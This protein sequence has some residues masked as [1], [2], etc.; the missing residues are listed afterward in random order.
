M[1][2]TRVSLRRPVAIL[3]LAAVAAVAAAVGVAVLSRGTDDERPDLQR[4]LDSLVTGPNRI[5]PGVAAYVAGPHGSWS[6]SAGVANA[7]TGARMRPDARFRLESV[8]KL[9]TATV[10]L[11]LVAEGKLRLDD[12]VAHRL[13][14][15]LPYGDRITVRELLDHTSGMVDTNDIDHNPAYY[16]GRVRDPALRAR[17][18][19]VARRVARDPG[20]EFSP[21]LWIRFAAALPLEYPPRTTYHYSNIGYMVAGLIAE[22]VGG[23]DLAKLVREQ[24][25]DPLGLDSAAYDPSAR[26][27]GSHAQGYTVGA[28]GK[29]TDT[30]TWT[31]G[32]G[33]NG[34]IVS[35]AADE[36]RFL[37]ALMRGELL[38]PP[39]LA[40]LKRPSDFSNYGLGT[41]IDESGCAGT[42]YGHN[43]GGSGY[44]TNVFVSGDGNRVAVLLL[45]GRTADSHGDEVAFE[46]M[47]RLYCAA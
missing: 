32:L 20:Y 35:D 15:L 23:A 29:L 13:P 24:I 31:E 27:G 1:T 22:R 6:G 21:R 7:A 8:S 19:A 40:A 2:T 16:I 45:N 33:A 10:I 43:G 11:Q 30:T 39:Q 5:A 36:A 34:G 25:A 28:H 4:I 42:V 37:Q 47:R 9:W 3:L 44:E 26:I 18:E 38:E 41:G 17:L 46:A 12:T 14:G